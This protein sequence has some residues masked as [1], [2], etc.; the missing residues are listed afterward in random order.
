MIL[1][2]ADTG[3]VLGKAVRVDAT[4]TFG[5]IKTGL[6]QYP[7]KTLAGEIVLAPLDFVCADTKTFYPDEDDIAN[8]IPDMAADEHKGSMGRVCI[9]AGSRGMTG[10]ATLSAMGAL[11]AGA[12]L[13]SVI[14]PDNLNAIMEVK[15]TEAMTV[16]A[17]CEDALTFEAAKKAIDS[18]A[19]DAYVI[20]QLFFQ[21]FIALSG[22]DD[23]LFFG[24]DRGSPF[25]GSAVLRPCFRQ[26]KAAPFALRTMQWMQGHENIIG[27]LRLLVNAHKVCVS[28]K[29]TQGL[30]ICKKT[31]SGCIKCNGRYFILRTKENDCKIRFAV[32]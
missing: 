1:M 12:G 13:V 10:A 11:R 2:D 27:R 23:F 4:V 22:E 32:L 16:P 9:I 3:A 24:H 8:M 18:V 21:L 30:R 7:G 28:V 26:Y 6:L 5:Y 29:K 20:V 17:A 15:L 25:N 31:A 19:A 14:I